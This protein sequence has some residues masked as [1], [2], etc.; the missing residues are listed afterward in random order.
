MTS[1]FV[2]GQIFIIPEL[3]LRCRTVVPV[4][5]DWPGVCRLLLPSRTGTA[6]TNTTFA[7]LQHQFAS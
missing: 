3:Y 6:Q 7:H 4:G 1:H 2:V 5:S